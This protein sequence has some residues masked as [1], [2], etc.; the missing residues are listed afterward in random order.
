MAQRFAYTRRP[1]HSRRAD[2]RRRADHAARRAKGRSAISPGR[3]TTRSSPR[4][5]RR[6]ARWWTYR[7]GASERQPLW[8]GRP[9]ATNGLRQ[10]TFS[11]RRQMG[12]GARDDEG[13]HRDS[14]G[15]PLMARPSTASALT[16]RASFPAFTASW[17]DRLHHRCAPDDSLRRRKEGPRA[18]S[19]CVWTDRLRCATTVYFASPND[20]GMVELWSA[21]LGTGHSRRASAFARDAYAPSIASDGTL[22][23]KVQS[24]RTF[25]RRCRRRLADRPGNW[26]PFNQKRRRI[27][28]PVR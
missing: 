24:Y 20:R 2:W 9:I 16:G 1:L 27:I 4:T 23:F 3:R 19:G 25:A 28:R 14:G 22:V 21:D 5:S 13:R 17:R 7:V 18:R 15:L 11:A 10:L 12:R 26:R 8:S 6:T